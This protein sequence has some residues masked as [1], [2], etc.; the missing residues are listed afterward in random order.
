MK[1]RLPAL[2]AAFLITTFIA[3]AM[4]AVSVG[5]LTNPN[6]VIA[7]NTP[8]TASGNS[9]TVGIQQAQIQQL[10]AR[11]QEY[12]QREQQYQSQLLNDQKQLQQADVELQQFQQ[13]ILALQSRGLIQIQNDG[14]VVVTGRSGN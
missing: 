9:S 12:Q 13:F 1:K 3:F 4:G 7:S 10:Q 8:G 11:I 6:S 5:A 2:F 14:S